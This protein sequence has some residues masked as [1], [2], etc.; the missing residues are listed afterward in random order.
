MLNGN[1]KINAVVARNIS[2]DRFKNS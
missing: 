2:P 1:I